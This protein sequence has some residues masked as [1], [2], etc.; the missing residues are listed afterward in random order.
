MIWVGQ[1]KFLKQK[2]A[3]T[4]KQAVFAGFHHLLF[5]LMKVEPQIAEI[6]F[7]YYLSS[8]KVR[9]TRDL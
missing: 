9:T 4:E 7:D 5:Q 3:G 1:S 6:V 2:L 8:R